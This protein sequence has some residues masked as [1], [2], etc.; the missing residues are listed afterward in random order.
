MGDAL[1]G[2]RSRAN[3]RKRGSC[4]CGWRA[5]FL[6]ASAVATLLFTAVAPLLVRW[7]TLQH[8]WSANVRTA[9]PVVV[10]SSGTAN[11]IP[12][13]GE[14]GVHGFYTEL[15]GACLHSLNGEGSMVVPGSHSTP[16]PPADLVP[17]TYVKWP[18]GYTALGFHYKSMLRA[19]PTSVP[20]SCYR[21]GRTLVLETSDAKPG[22][23]GHMGENLM[24]Y[25]A[26]LPQLARRPAGEPLVDT[27]LV[28][29]YGFPAFPT[30]DWEREMLLSALGAASPADG[31]VAVPPVL[32]AHGATLPGCSMTCFEQLIWPQCTQKWLMSEHHANVLRQRVYDYCG[33]DGGRTVGEPGAEW[34]AALPRLR[35]RMLYVQRGTSTRHVT[36]KEQLL[37]WAAEA[38]FDIIP[39]PRNLT[40]FCAQVALFASADLVVGTHGSH[41]TNIA[42][43]RPHSVVIE[44]SPHHFYWPAFKI[45]AGHARLHYLEWR[46]PFPSNEDGRPEVDDG[47]SANIIVDA[48]VQRFL[49]YAHH[50]VTVGA[51]WQRSDC[52]GPAPVTAAPRRQGLQEMVAVRCVPPGYV[53]PTA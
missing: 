46:N 15:R 23:I 18:A 44:L 29:A 17:F 41:L 42:W 19:E 28:L 25:H 14:Y 32:I 24:K 31:T 36:N 6:A 53:M 45:V 43:M 37:S 22:H 21:T 11:R 38:G 34:G 8:A 50:L 35:P 2:R 40:N 12:L 3:L 13:T 27:L 7:P 10:L 5:R 39:A 9:Y 30:I 47:K 4:V 49:A 33:L 20:A 52:T 16:L 26:V 1:D 51:P 48:D